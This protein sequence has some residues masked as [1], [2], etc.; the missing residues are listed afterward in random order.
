MLIIFSDI[1]RIVHN[2]FILSDQTLNSEHCC[3]FYG[4]CVKMCEVLARSLATKELAVAPQQRTVLHFPFHHINMT[5]VP[6]PPYFSLFP[7]LKI[8]LKFRHFDTTE[9]NSQDA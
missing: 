5:I 2:E 9:V 4:D 7:R 8:K 3:D 1:K 6:L